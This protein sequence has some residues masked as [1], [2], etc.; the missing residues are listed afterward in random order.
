MS[1][2]VD[3][4]PSDYRT[5]KSHW[6]YSHQAWWAQ[7]MLARRKK[8]AISN[9]LDTGFHRALLAHRILRTILRGVRSN[10]LYATKIKRDGH[11]RWLD[12]IRI[13]S[14]VIIRTIDLVQRDRQLRWHCLIWRANDPIIWKPIRTERNGKSGFLRRWRNAQEIIIRTLGA[15]GRHGHLWWLDLIRL[16]NKPS[17]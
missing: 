12:L 10:Y 7:R 2:Q 9:H 8:G 15:T 13:T 16:A 3:R 17:N 1:T 14:N 4:I 5:I 11:I 6:R